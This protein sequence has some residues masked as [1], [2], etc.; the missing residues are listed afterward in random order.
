MPA[1]TRFVT[2]DLVFETAGGKDT[3]TVVSPQGYVQDGYSDLSG[4]YRLG[5]GGNISLD[6]SADQFVASGNIVH[7]VGEHTLKVGAEYIS[8]DLEY[9]FSRGLHLLGSPTNIDFRDYGGDFPA[10]RPHIFGAY[11]QDKIEAGGMVANVG[12]RAEMFAGGQDAY[13]YGAPSM[14]DLDL[15]GTTMGKSYFDNLVME[16]G[17]KEEWG[18]VPVATSG[19]RTIQD[20]L[21]RNYPD[22]KAPTPGDVAASVPR[23]AGKQHWRLS[24]RLGLSH[25]VSDHTKFFFNYGVFHTLQK[26]A[27]MYGMSPG[28]VIG[29]IGRLN[30]VYNPNLRPA[31]TTMYEVGVE[32]LFPMDILLTLRGYAKYNTDQP[33]QLRVE[34]VGFGGYYTYR[35]ANYEDIRGTEIKI[36]RSGGRFLNGWLTYERTTSHSGQV[37]L[38]KISDDPTRV[39]P[40]N[41]YVRTSKPKGFIR[42]LLRLGTPRDWGLVAGG[43]SL[44]IIQAYRSGGEVIHNPDQLEIREIPDEYFIPA[45]DYWNT[46]LKV[47]KAVSLP[48]GRSLSAYLDVTNIWNTKR[49]NGFGISNLDDY[50]EY[51]VG[52]RRGGDDVKYGD[53]STFYVL[54]RPYRD[55]AGSWRAP[56]SPRTEWLHHLN[57]RH[58]RLGVRFGL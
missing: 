43:W 4:T 20:S 14:F 55:G 39:T 49:M 2:K 13:V 38:S 30:F 29:A 12:V 47:S 33:T 34:G 48:G 28:G 23:T 15:F 18:P 58:Y 16:A 50:R 5:G 21:A 25:P 1:K 52:R 9:H 36:A 56:I 51:L 17:W 32:H 54:T 26:G 8:G 31:K 35:N 7:A 19:Y 42:G 37:G 3:V 40:Y 27:L 24:P 57:P 11:V 10:A 44:S 53:E 41:P 22:A 46:D 6:A 45:V